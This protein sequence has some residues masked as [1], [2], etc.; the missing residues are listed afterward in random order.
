V[1][2]VALFRF[3]KDGA[4]SADF[5]EQDLQAAVRLKA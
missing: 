2:S 4:V 1:F 5:T 3:A